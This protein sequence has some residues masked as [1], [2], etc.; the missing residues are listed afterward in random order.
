MSRRPRYSS[1]GGRRFYAVPRVSFLCA[2]S[3][4]FTRA[5]SDALSAGG[6]LGG[7]SLRCRVSGRTL[8]VGEVK[9]C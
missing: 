1:A 9:R 7:V 3:P 8:S 6:P 5:A 4:F 2:P